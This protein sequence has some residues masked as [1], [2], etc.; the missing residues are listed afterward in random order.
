M[1]VGAQK[2]KAPATKATQVKPEVVS[3]KVLLKVQKLIGLF[4][5]CPTLNIDL[6][7]LNIYHYQHET[8]V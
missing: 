6:K 5:Y 3:M 2:A 8:S 1:K 7:R 4:T